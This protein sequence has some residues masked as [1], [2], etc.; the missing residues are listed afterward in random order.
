MRPDQFVIALATSLALGAA[1]QAAPVQLDPVQI[2]EDL[3]EKSEDYGARDVERLVEELTEAITERL[4]REGHSIVTGPAE[5]RIAVTL[6]NAWPNRPTR[7]QLADRPGLSLRSI[8]L[9]GASV[10]AVLYDESG[11]QTGEIE[12]SW[13]THHISDSVGQTTWSDAERTFDRFARSLAEELPG[14]PS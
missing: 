13:R 9:G 6:E 10:S 11:A 3:A 7:E 4:E 1:A 14:D 2:G 12:Y 8:S 5:I